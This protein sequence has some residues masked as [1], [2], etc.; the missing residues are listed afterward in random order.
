MAYV[1]QELKAQLSP[2]IR[3]VLKKHGVK[4]TIAVRN[5]STLEVNIRQGS[6]DFIGNLNKTCADL[7]P[8]FRP[9]QGSVS[10]NTYHYQRQYTGQALRFLTE[11]ISAMN[12]GN[13]DNSDIQSDYFDVGWYVDVNIGRWNQPY[14]V[15]K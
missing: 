2:Q 10:V 3:A 12:Q 9:A 5:H 13:H 8:D 14:A 6:I 4:G 7:Y 11:L 15:I 1:S